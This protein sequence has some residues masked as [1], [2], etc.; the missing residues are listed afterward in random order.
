[1]MLGAANAERGIT[2]DHHHPRFDIDESA[3][4]MGTRLLAGAAVELLAV[5]AAPAEASAQMG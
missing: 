3:L 5:E 2:H 4:A 1:V